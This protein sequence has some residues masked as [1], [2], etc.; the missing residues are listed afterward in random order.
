MRLWYFVRFGKSQKKAT[1]DNKNKNGFT[2][3]NFFPRRI[4]NSLKKY[5]LRFISTHINYVDF[6]LLAT[7]LKRSTS[8]QLRRRLV[9]STIHLNNKKIFLLFVQFGWLFVRFIRNTLQMKC[10]KLVEKNIQKWKSQ[11]NCLISPSS[12]FINGCVNKQIHYDILDSSYI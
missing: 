7:L 1:R 10:L 8:K 6:A 12:H 9:D 2:N 4:R 11:A 5:S 3:W